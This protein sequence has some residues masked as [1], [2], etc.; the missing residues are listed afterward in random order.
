MRFYNDP[1]WEL[2]IIIIQVVWNKTLKKLH[3]CVAHLL[4]WR[5]LL[6]RKS[7]PIPHRLAPTL[8]VDDGEAAG[9]WCSRA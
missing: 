3:H 9:A 4:C 5:G 6:A 8:G 1:K 7:G 2:P